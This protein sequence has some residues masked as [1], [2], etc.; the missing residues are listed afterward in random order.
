MRLRPSGNKGPVAVSL[1]AFRRYH[2]RIGLDLG[3]H[4]ADARARGGRPAGAARPHRGGDRGG[5]GA[6]RRRRSASAPTPPSMR[7]RMLRDLPPEGPWDVKLRAGGQIE[8][9]FIA[10]VLQLIHAREAPELCS[11]TTRIA[12]ARLA[13]AGHVA[14]GRCGA[15]DPRR[16]RLAHRAGHAAHHRRP[17]RARGAAGRLRACAAARGRRAMDR[18]GRLTWRGCAARWMTWRAR[19]APRSSDT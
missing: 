17:R 5:A 7:A 8:V 13:K 10:Q 19:S 15:A 12:L 18:T 14:G 11:P 16:P 4:G 1:G 2:A 9:E 6:G 3:A